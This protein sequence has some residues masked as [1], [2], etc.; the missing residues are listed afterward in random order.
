MMCPWHNVCEKNQ[1]RIFVGTNVTR[2][3]SH[4]KGEDDDGE[5]ERD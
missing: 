1:V 3:L 4:A 5:T 2:Y